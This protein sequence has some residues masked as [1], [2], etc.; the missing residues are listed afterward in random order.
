MR[1]PCALAVSLVLTCAGP[2]RAQYHAARTFS[3]VYGCAGP[4]VE[5]RLR[6]VPRQEALPPPRACPEEGG[7]ESAAYSPPAYSLPLVQ[8]FSGGYS[9]SGFSGFSG[10]WGGYGFAPRLSAFDLGSYSFAP[11]LF[12]LAHGHSFA[13]RLHGFGHSFDFGLHS[14]AFTPRFHHGFGHDFHFRS[15]FP[16]RFAPVFAGRQQFSLSLRSDSSVGHGRRGLLG[17]LLGRLRDR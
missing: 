14:R 4:A 17:R 2:A 15:G 8:S 10:F 1:T 13:P 6:I 16:S 5:I 7:Y 12:G 11:R 3:P 9:A